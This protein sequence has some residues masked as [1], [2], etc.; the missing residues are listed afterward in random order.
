MKEERL[1][2]MLRLE[3][4][5]STSITIQDTLIIFAN[6]DAQK[7]R[8]FV[9]RIQKCFLLG[10]QDFLWESVLFSYA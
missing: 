9:V 5:N 2:E 7:G 8:D 4:D 6:F 3:A 10:N 1:E